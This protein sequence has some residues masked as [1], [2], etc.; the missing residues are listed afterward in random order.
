MFIGRD[1]SCIEEDDSYN[2]HIVRR[3]MDGLGCTDDKS[4]TSN[5]LSEKIPLAE[6]LMEGCKN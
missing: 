5:Y 2:Y 3:Y 4:N 6:Y 1:C